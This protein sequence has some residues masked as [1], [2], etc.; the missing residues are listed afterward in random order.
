MNFTYLYYYRAVAQTEHMTKA[1]KEL[2]VTQPALSRAIAH[3]ERDVGQPLFIRKNNRLVLN[4]A[5]KIFLNVTNDILNAWEQGIQDIAKQT[6]EARIILN[7]S[8]AGASIPK[9]VQ[10]FCA[11]HPN[12]VFTIQSSSNQLGVDLFCDFYL[13]SSVSE[14]PPP[15]AILLR[16]EQLYLIVSNSNPLSKLDSVALRDCQ[17]LPFLFADEKNDMYTI[18]MHYC[19]LA[20]FKPNVQL[21]VE[22]Q[23]ILM[24]LVSLNQG[25]TLSVRGLANEQRVPIPISDIPCYRYVYM[26]TNPRH[27]TTPILEA[28]QSFA[29][30]YFSNA[31]VPFHDE[32]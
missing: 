3:L 13:F 15:N 32:V 20:G 1:A 9:L 12:A 14:V 29:V 27:E 11:Q 5:G 25:V 28:F 7:V 2:N 31:Q 8:S 21:K 10:A 17:N 4:E 18:Q 23:N 22:K 6:K 19:N 26:L 16:R 24:E 30:R